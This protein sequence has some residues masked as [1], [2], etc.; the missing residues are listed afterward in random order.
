MS[1]FTNKELSYG[2][3]KVESNQVQIYE[4]NYQRR[5]LPTP[6]GTVKEAYWQ[7]NTIHVKMADGR[8]YV[9]DEFGN[10]SSYFYD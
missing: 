2:R 8:H 3:C 9:Y 6:C 5:A 4:S 1:A 10:Y 7:N